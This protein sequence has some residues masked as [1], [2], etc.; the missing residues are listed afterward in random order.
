MRQH[1]GTSRIF[2]LERGRDLAAA[3]DRRLDVG[4]GIE[5]AL[6]VLRSALDHFDMGLNTHQDVVEL[7]GNVTLIHGSGDPRS[8]WFRHG[9]TADALRSRSQGRT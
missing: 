8:G 1:S 9:S 3:L 4:D 2:V 7:M 5:D 6:V